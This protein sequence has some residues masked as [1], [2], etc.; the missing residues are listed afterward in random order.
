MPFGGEKACSACV[1]FC[2][3]PPNH[4]AGRGRHTMTG[5]FKQARIVMIKKNGKSIIYK[6][7][8]DSP[9]G[10][11]KGESKKQ[12]TG[13]FHQ[14]PQ[15][16]PSLKSQ[17]LETKQAYYSSRGEASRVSGSLFN[18]LQLLWLQWPTRNWRWNSAIP[19]DSG[20]ALNQSF[21]SRPSER[22]LYL[23]TP[24]LSSQSRQHSHSQTCL[25][26]LT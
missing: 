7:S 9:Q 15:R 8:W 16:M 23:C 19:M 13:F 6:L 22:W 5:Y 1:R 20:K 12:E 10:K 17:R 14:S 25:T 4:R 24:N 18:W 3:Q 11:K 21:I 2:V 26:Q